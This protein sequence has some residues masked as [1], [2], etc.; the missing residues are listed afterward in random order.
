MLGHFD[1][2]LLKY[3]KKKI[4]KIQVC[5]EI[6]R[7]SHIFKNRTFSPNTSILTKN[8]FFIILKAK[9]QNVPI[10]SNFWHL[11]YVI[12]SPLADVVSFYLVAFIKKHPVNP[13]CIY[14]WDW[15]WDFNYS[16]PSHSDLIS[17]HNNWLMILRNYIK[18][19]SLCV[20]KHVFCI[21]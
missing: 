14:S 20:S 12:R 11:S 17:W 6:A 19:K 13:R 4:F 1:I 9:Y 5:E 16:E 2:W 15:K 21:F 3:K 7:F 10:I 8:V 18:P